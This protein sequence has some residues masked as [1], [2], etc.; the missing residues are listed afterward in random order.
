MRFRLA[1]RSDWQRLRDYVATLPWVRDGKQVVY[2]V[3]VEELAESKTEAQ[4]NAQHEWYSLAASQL[5]DSTAEWYRGYCKLHF[6]VPILR[7]ASPEYRVAYDRVIR[8]LPYEHK[9]IM[10]MAPI[11]FPVT[12]GMNKKQ[13]SEY[14]DAVYQH[15]RGLGVNLEREAA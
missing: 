5:Q 6:G 15:L 14:L 1:N 7:S 3:T 8:P 10:M 2:R 9:I 12:R 13:L 11:D 4:N